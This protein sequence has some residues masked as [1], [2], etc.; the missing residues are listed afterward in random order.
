MIKLWNKT[1]DVQPKALDGL[2]ARCSLAGQHLELVYRPG[3]QG[4][5]PTA[6]TRNGR[7]LP[8]KRG[9]NPYRSGAAEVAMADLLP[10]LND[11]DNT[12]EVRLG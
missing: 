7:D 8:F 4:C 11:G 12:L 2:R 3:A 5:G 9:A 10:R 6:L 1:K